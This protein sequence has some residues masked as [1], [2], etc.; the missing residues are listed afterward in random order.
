MQGRCGPGHFC[1]IG[2]SERSSPEN[3]CVETFFC[4][5]GAEHPLDGDPCPQGH[6]CSEDTQEPIL[7]SPGLYSFNP[8]YLTYLSDFYCPSDERHSQS[9]CLRNG[10]LLSH[11]VGKRRRLPFFSGFGMCIHTYVRR[12]V[13]KCVLRDAD[14]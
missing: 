3:L 6:Y 9:A 1:L 13:Q 14:R 5:S 11:R 4:E 10:S 8:T 12:G 2:E 7:C